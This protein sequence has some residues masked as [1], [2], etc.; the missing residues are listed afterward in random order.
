[1]RKI[2]N[3][4]TRGHSPSNNSGYKPCR[5]CKHNISVHFKRLDEIIFRCVHCKCIDYIPSDNL[6][7]LEWMVNKKDS[8][9]SSQG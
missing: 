1:V 5:Y 8:N 6:E 2:L 4:L 9:E 3:W 7:Y